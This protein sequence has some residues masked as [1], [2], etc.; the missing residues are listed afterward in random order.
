[1]KFFPIQIYV[2]E[3]RF[4]LQLSRIPWEL[5]APHERQALLNHDQSLERLAERCGLS[6]CE[7]IAVLEDRRWSDME[8]VS[9]IQKLKEIVQRQT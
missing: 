7:A 9:A 5:I 4:P 3:D 1:M 2:P 6:A 8:R